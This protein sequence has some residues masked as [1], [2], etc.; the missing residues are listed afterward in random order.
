MNDPVDD[1]TTLHIKIGERRQRERLKL[2]LP[3]YVRSL[4]PS[5]SYKKE[6]TETTNF[7]CYGLCFMSSHHYYEMG[8]SLLV[9]F[10]F[11]PGTTAHMQYV[12]EVVRVEGLPTGEKIV[13][14]K[15]LQFP[16]KVHAR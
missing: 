15:F 1:R 14:V 6:V 4:T 3:A 12:A 9:K 13:A 16:A 5:E 2:Q 7:N 10:P 8:M 11:S